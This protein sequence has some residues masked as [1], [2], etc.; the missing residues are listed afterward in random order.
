MIRF[1]RDGAGPV[2]TQVGV[3]FALGGPVA[4]LHPCAGATPP[5]RGRVI[6]TE[7]AALT[8]RVWIDL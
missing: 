6:T 4:G 2:G 8:T 1:P 5:Y 3:N 7:V